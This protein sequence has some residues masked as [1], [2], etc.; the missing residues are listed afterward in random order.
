MTKFSLQFLS[1]ILLTLLIDFIFGAKFIPNEKDDAR[2]RHEIFGHNLKPNII[3]TYIFS[4]ADSKDGKINFCTDKNGFRVACNKKNLDFYEINYDIVVLGDSIAEGTGVEYNKTF[5]GFFEKK[6]NQKVVNLGVNGYSFSNY[7]SKIHYYLNQ[8]L[9]TNKVVMT[10]STVNDWLQYKN[11]HSLNFE[12]TKY[13]KVIWNES[14]KEKKNFKTML[15][16][17]FPLSYLSLWKIKNYFFPFKDKDVVSKNLENLRKFDYVNFN[18]NHPAFFVLDK[19]NEL[20][21]EKN[22]DFY[23][24]IFPSPGNFFI[25]NQ[26]YISTMKEYC[27]KKDCILINLFDDFLNDSNYKEYYLINDDHFN[28]KGHKYFSDAIIKNLN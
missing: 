21:S 23:I 3:K 22:V 14:F 16:N 9:I 10:I 25:N 24:V 19:M 18:S 26:R 6:Y 13:P 28:I 20:F 4:N 11:E 1:A 17:I 12:D 27:L 15:K 2:H 7:Y 5:S 8:G